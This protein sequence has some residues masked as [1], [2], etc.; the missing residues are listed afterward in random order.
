MDSGIGFWNWIL[1]FD[2]EVKFGNWILKL[3]SEGNKNSGPK[4]G[5]YKR[6]NHFTNLDIQKNI[7][8][9]KSVISKN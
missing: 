6:S 2:F 5:L 7:D 4:K 1:E 9:N 8:K 3:D